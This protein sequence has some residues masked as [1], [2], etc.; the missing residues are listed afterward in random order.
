MREECQTLV[1]ELQALLDTKQMLDAEIAIYRKMLEGEE[2][3]VGLRQMVE[4]VVKTHSL[5]QQ[6]DTD[7]TR[8][9]RGEVST[10]TTFQRS[11]KGNVTIAECDPNGKFIMLENSHRSKD[12]N[13]GE[14][15]L[16]RKL[17]N[18]REI[19][20]IIPPNTV[21]KAG[22]TMKIWAR[23]QGGIHSPPESLVYDGE[24]TWGIGA[25]VVTTLINKDGDERATHTQ[26][27]I[28]TGQ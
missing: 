21:L 12:E 17:D 2:S 23:D 22:R 26:K 4:Q 13:L 3:R 5:Q 25:N 28:Q 7:S 27:T 11:A 18:R 10:K 19:V 1:A 16:R 8:S 14:H 15:K 6:E 9:V 24:N 20:Y